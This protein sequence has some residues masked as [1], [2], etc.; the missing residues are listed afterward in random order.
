MPLHTLNDHR[1]IIM[2]FIEIQ[3]EKW[4]TVFFLLL[5]LLF[6]SPYNAENRGDYCQQPCVDEQQHRWLFFERCVVIQFLINF[7]FITVIVLKF[8]AAMSMTII[9]INHFLH[10]LPSSSTSSSLLLKK[11]YKLLMIGDDVK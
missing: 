4:L 5:R 2:K 3:Q 11:S 8:N 9:S 7:S 10:N 1:N 6:R